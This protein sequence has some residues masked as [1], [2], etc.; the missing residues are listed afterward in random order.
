MPFSSLCTI[1]SPVFIFVIGLIN[2]IYIVFC[3]YDFVFESVSNLDLWLPEETNIIY[4][5]LM[6]SLTYFS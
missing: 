1:Y 3:V 4:D 2:Y 6:Y 5:L